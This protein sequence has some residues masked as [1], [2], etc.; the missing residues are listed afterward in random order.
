MT[1]TEDACVEAMAATG[2]KK[3]TK[4]MVQEIASSISEKL[5]PRFPKDLLGGI[6]TAAY[7]TTFMDHIAFV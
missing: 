2:S 4:R 6:Y 7:V 1:P 5:P 3:L